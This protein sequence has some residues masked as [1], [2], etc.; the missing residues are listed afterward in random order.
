M[1]GYMMSLKKYS[2]QLYAKLNLIQIF[3]LWGV[4]TK[5]HISFTIAVILLF[6]YFGTLGFIQFIYQTIMIMIL[7]FCLISHEYGHALAAKRYDITTHDIVITPVGGVARIVNLFANP[8]QEIVIAIA[9][10]LV[11]IVYF[12]IGMLLYA[13]EIPYV[14]YF[15][16]Y[17]CLINIIM[18]VFN[19]IPAYPM[20]G[21][22]VLRAILTYVT[23]DKIISHK[24]SIMISQF[25]SVCFIILGFM[26]NLI[27]VIIIAV[28]LLVLAQA[29]KHDKTIYRIKK[30]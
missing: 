28:L 16:Y 7:M 12:C 11:N 14:H 21:G 2:K 8:K 4:P 20:D 22:R 26:Y 1:V 15:V 27:N 17:F 29:E 19:L 10:P 25:I 30:L 18:G 23:K 13:F 24:I 6:I 9:G 3:K 5:L